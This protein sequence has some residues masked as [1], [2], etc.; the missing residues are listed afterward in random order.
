[1]FGVVFCL[2][3]DHSSNYWKG[4]NIRWKVLERVR[5]VLGKEEKNKQTKDEVD[6]SLFASCRKREEEQKWELEEILES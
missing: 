3:G 5:E 2:N 4:R 6:F 1:M